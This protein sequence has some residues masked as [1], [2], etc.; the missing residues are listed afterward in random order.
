MSYAL[1]KLDSDLLR[2][3][4]AVAEAGSITEGSQR[5]FRSQS[6]ASL[7]IK[8]LEEIVEQ[9]VFER[10][11]RGIVLTTAGENLRPVAQR[12]VD[13]LDSALSELRANPLTG[14]IRLGIPD[15]YG[16]T[17]LPR[18]IASFCRDNSDVELTVRCAC[19]TDF[20]EALK[21]GELDVAV[22]DAETVEPP[23]C[24]LREQRTSWV[25]SRMHVAHEQDPLPI[26]LFDRACWW[27]GRALDAL[28]QMNR[29]F[30]IVYTGESV[31]GVSAAVEAGVAIGLLGESSVKP[32][33]LVLD[34]T[35]GFPTLPA[36]HLVLDWRDDLDPALL[37]A[38]RTAFTMA[39]QKLP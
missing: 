33:F 20:P 28:T 23:Q 8:R 34:E 14:A 4:L 5:I 38:V 26:A 11:G 25:S 2:T 21:R 16:D 24:V 27:R 29:D 9:P 12:V 22:F 15:E 36:S 35:H 18:V 39:F 37:D 1:E 6:A 7:Q 19:S 17:V 32:G 10:H 3:F 13:L 30:R 31:A